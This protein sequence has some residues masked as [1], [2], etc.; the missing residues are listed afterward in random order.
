MRPALV[1]L[2]LLRYL[3]TSKSSIDFVVAVSLCMMLLLVHDDI[4]DKEKVRRGKKT[5]NYL[6]GNQ[7][8]SSFWRLYICESK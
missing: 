8:A 1:L 7:I 3:K 6:W 2:L 5:I 4:I